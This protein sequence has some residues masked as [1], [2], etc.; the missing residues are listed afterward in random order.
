MGALKEN[1]RLN[2]IDA[3]KGFGIFC[4]VYGH[5]SRDVG[6]LSQAFYSFHV[7]LCVFLSGYLYHSKGKS[8][9]DHLKK[10]GY[11]LLLPYLIWSI[12]SIAIYM[13]MG[14]VAASAFGAE[15]YSF[16]ENVL[17]MLL[18]RSIGN[19]A[20]WYLP[21]LFVCYL[22]MYGYCRLL[23]NASVDTAGKKALVI[24]A[25]VLF[26]VAA[27]SVYT[28]YH[29]IYPMDIPF[30]I[31]N[32]CFLFFFFWLGY[33]VKKTVKLPQEKKWLLPALL[34]IAVSVFCALR[35]N[36]EVEYMRLTDSDYG[37]N[38][39]VFFVTALGSSL[40]ICW[41]AMILGRN[42]LFE[43]FGRYSL[44]ILVMHK[45]PVLFFQ[46]IFGRLGEAMG[47]FQVMWF[48]LISVLS[49][50]MCCGVGAILKKILPWTVGEYKKI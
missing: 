43:W 5:A 1:D 12:I 27:L 7:P 22:M 33:V 30:G 24:G 19:A 32:A 41:T 10:T 29:Y 45:F 44:C 21:F 35:F 18:G 26:S 8:L 38:I 14:A 16:K 6:L 28:K 50:A 25:P 40:G 13:V 23:K 15:T 4:I 37:R 42:R 11:R 36:D 2:W 47:S 3:A 31:S 17:T 39:P 48:L 9:G 34:L 46:V 20:L 49:M